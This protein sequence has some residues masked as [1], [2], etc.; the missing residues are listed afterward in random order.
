MTS[1]IAS[2][3]LAAQFRFAYTGVCGCHIGFLRRFS[4]N[5]LSS[6][7]IQFVP[8]LHFILYSERERGRKKTSGNAA[9][10]RAAKKLK[11]IV[12]EK[13]QAKMFEEALGRMGLDFDSEAHMCI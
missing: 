2:S 1:S 6:N 13:Q 5:S 9:Q 7:V 11:K 3:L 8:A 4:V 10:K 12:G